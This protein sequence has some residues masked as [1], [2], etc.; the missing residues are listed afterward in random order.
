MVAIYSDIKYLVSMQYGSIFNHILTME[1]ADVTHAIVLRRQLW[2]VCV[3]M[4]FSELLMVTVLTPQSG[5]SL[6]D[7]ARSMPKFAKSV[8]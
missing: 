3:R 2:R 8:P 6:C 7:D 1:S 5:R 4:R